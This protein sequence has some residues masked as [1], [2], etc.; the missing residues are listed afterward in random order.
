MGLSCGFV[1]VDSA[2]YVTSGVGDVF[3][4]FQY[5]V[6]TGQIVATIGG[7]TVV[8]ESAVT[9]PSTTPT[10]T[11]S[12]TPT[13]TPTSTS[14]TPTTTPTTTPLGAGQSGGD[15][16]HTVVIVVVV[17]V[18]GVLL[19]LGVVYMRRRKKPEE[20]ANRFLHADRRGKKGGK[21]QLLVALDFVNPAFQQPLVNPTMDVGEPKDSDGGG[22]DL[23][24]DV[25][26]SGQSGGQDQDVRRSGQSGNL[27][28]DVRLGGQS[29]S[30]DQ[31]RPLDLKRG[32]AKVTSDV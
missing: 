5:A 14:T 19:I 7:S 4:A 24:A 30:Q 6:Q 27:N 1:V 22:G 15:S 25:S 11:P 10:T 12:T 17:V 9:T 26:L 21:N 20:N 32:R 23:N 2:V 16:D 13:T 3:V 8:A 28:A 31:G 29:G 18:V